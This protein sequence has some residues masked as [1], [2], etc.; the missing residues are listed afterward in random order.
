MFELAEALR[1]NDD[2]VKAIEEEVGKPSMCWDMVPPLELVAAVLKHTGALE[3]IAA[4]ELSLST[5][6]EAMSTALSA[7][8]MLSGSMKRVADLD[9]ALHAA[10]RSPRGV[11]P[12]SAL[13]FYDPKKWRRRGKS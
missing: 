12:P 7:T 13:P 8:E 6:Q 1:L 10:I 9:K 3:L 11:V 4:L 2:V 5:A